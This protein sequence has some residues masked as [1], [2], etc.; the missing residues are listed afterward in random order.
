MS[1]LMQCYGTFFLGCHH[2][3]LLLQ[4]TDDAVNGIEE[5]LLAYNLTVVTGSYECCL[6]AHVCNVST[7][8]SW[9]LACQQ[10]NV[11]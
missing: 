5:I 2:L 8:E 10:V 9:R 6:V 4:S 7:R 11:K 3:C 1:S